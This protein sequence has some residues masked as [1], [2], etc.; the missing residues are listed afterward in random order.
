[1]VVFMF[2]GVI[3]DLGIVDYVILISKDLIIGFF[4]VILILLNCK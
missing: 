2:L 1:M 3:L 4:G